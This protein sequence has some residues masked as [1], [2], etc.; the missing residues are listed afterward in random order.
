MVSNWIRDILNFCAIG[1]FD[2]ISSFCWRYKVEPYKKEICIEMGVRGL[3]IQVGS[4]YSSFLA[5]RT[6]H[7]MYELNGAWGHFDEFRLFAGNTK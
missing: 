6:D 4:R 2:W 3:R 7:H 5:T 1:H